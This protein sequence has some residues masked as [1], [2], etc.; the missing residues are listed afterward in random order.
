MLSGT[1]DLLFQSIVQAE[2]VIDNQ[3]RSFGGRKNLTDRLSR[4]FHSDYDFTRALG[5]VAK[6]KP[7]A[8]FKSASI[9]S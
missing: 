3:Q 2:S 5:Y 4:L 7:G 6:A 1:S 9:K 8:F